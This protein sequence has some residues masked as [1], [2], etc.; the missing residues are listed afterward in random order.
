MCLLWNIVAVTTAWIKGEGWCKSTKH[1]SYIIIFHLLSELVFSFRSN[2]L[3]SCYHLLHIR[4]SWSLCFVVSSSLSCNEVLFFGYSLLGIIFFSS[5]GP[6]VR[7]MKILPMSY[8]FKGV[9]PP[10]RSLYS[11]KP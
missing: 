2:D 8:T 10:F 7:P 3:V 9:F 1:S 4:G 6:L 11:L 5:P